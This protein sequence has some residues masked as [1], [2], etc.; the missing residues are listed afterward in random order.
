MGIVLQ[1][2]VL[3][4]KLSVQWRLWKASH[5]LI[6]AGLVIA[7]WWISFLRCQ[8]IRIRNGWQFSILVL[9]GFGL[10]LGLFLLMFNVGKST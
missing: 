6:R 1:L 3:I 2:Q 8:P 5:L 7:A 9:V 4:F 10:Y